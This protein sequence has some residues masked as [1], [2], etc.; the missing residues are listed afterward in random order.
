ML[1]FRVEQLLRCLVALLLT[2]SLNLFPPV[3]LAWGTDVHAPVSVSIVLVLVAKT[4][5]VSCLDRPVT[6]TV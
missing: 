5:A 4:F 2:A 6:M 1:K 3:P